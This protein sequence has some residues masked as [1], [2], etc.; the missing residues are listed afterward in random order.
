MKTIYNIHSFRTLDIGPRYDA[1]TAFV[2]IFKTTLRK[3]D[4]LFLRGYDIVSA[5]CVRSY[6]RAPINQGHF[7]FVQQRV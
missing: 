2:S 3:F 6:P 5:A 1:N 7:I 4:G